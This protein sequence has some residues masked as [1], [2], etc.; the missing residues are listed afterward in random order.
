MYP[1]CNFSVSISPDILTFALEVFTLALD[2]LT[3]ALD[4][5]ISALNI[6]KY[7]PRNLY[8]RAKYV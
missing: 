5:F 4:V 8:Y 7:R 3:I 1:E 2:V 6:F